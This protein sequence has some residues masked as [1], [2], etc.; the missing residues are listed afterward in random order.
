DFTHAL[1]RHTLYEGLSP[2]R[3]VRLHRTIAEAMEAVLGERGR[4][5]AAEIARHYRG[6][7][8]LP[9]AER[10]VQYCLSA[11]EQAEHAAAF[12]EASDHLH[13]ALTLLPETA[14]SRPR[15]VGRLAL[16]LAWALRFDESSVVARDA[17]ARIADSESRDAAAD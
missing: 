5:H 17:A 7:A 10:G 12:A 1:V 15:L 13:A 16:A 9:G 3:Q 14:P 2:A 8:G 4:E 11:A 6:S